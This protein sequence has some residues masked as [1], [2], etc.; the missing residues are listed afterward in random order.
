M[1]FK[2]DF[3]ESYLKH[4]LNSVLFMKVVSVRK[5]FAVLIY[6]LKHLLNRYK[7]QLNLQLLEDVI[8]KHLLVFNKK[9]TY[10]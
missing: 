6:Y 2:I 10:I 3:R 8:L 5:N 1:L 4:I 7:T 9:I